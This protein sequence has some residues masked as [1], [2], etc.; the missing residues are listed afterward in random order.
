MASKENRDAAKLLIEAAEAGSA[1]LAESLGS[2][3]FSKTLRSTKV[4]TAIQAWEVVKSETGESLV[5]LALKPNKPSVA[6][7]VKA[8]VAAGCDVNARD[9]AGRTPLHAAFVLKALSPFLDVIVVALLDVG[10]DARA[11]DAAGQ[12]PAAYAAGKSGDANGA[13]FRARLALDRASARAALNINSNAT[14]YPSPF[15]AFSPPPTTPLSLP[16]SLHF[17]PGL[18][19]GPHLIRPA[20][21]V[22]PAAALHY[23]VL[24]VDAAPQGTPG[25]RAAMRWE[26]IGSPLARLRSS[27][28]TGPGRAAELAGAGRRPAVIELRRAAPAEGDVA[29]EN[30]LEKTEDPASGYRVA[31]ALGPFSGPLAAVAARKFAALWREVMAGAG[32]AESE[33][34]VAACDAAGGDAGGGACPLRTG[35]GPCD[36]AAVAAL[37]CIVR[38]NCV[39]SG[40]KAV[41]SA[42]PA[43]PAAEGGEDVPVPVPV[44]VPPPCTADMSVSSDPSFLPAAAREAARLALKDASDRFQPALEA[45]RKRLVEKAGTSLTAADGVAHPNALVI[46]M[47]LC[48]ARRANVSAFVAVEAAK[49]AAKSEDEM[50]VR[51]PAEGDAS[52]RASE[53]RRAFGSPAAPRVSAMARGPPSGTLGRVN[54]SSSGDFASFLSPGA[55][56][57]AEPQRIN[58]PR[59]PLGA[60]AAASSSSSNLNDQ[61]GGGGGTLAYSRV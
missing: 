18:S 47:E 51:A 31:A 46:A 20:S 26:D 23:A 54:N 35:D 17:S 11:R 13:M 53:A 27:I 6:A 16:F 14:T 60:A 58:T 24:L 38:S 21:A 22:R 50:A 3:H 12:T 39:R 43:P 41:S 49:L 30:T 8:L 61:E 34:C 19:P 44:P 15:A 33:R 25:A 2:G 10:A 36:F 28:P 37:F 5:H 7:A 32:L 48:K 59:P 9:L 40:D 57:F 52:S 56:Q 29:A 4:R 42:L 55:R 1:T 45:L